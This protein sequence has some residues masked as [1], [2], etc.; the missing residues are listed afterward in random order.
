MNSKKKK[1]IMC[2]E[3]SFIICLNTAI[4]LKKKK[5]IINFDFVVNSRAKK[6][7]VAYIWQKLLICSGFLPGIQ[8]VF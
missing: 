7:Y 8:K 4:F 6:V 1:R 3:K 5:R 2:K